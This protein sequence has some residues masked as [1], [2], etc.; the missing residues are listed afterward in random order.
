MKLSWEIPLFSPLV[1]K[2]GQGGM[3]PGRTGYCDKLI[4]GRNP[5]VATMYLSLWGT[6][7][8]GGEKE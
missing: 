2:T 7:E 4:Y 8:L 1:S 3:T 5:G 6:S